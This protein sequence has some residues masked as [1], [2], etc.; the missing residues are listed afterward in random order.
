[1]VKDLTLLDKLV[2]KLG[3]EEKHEYLAQQIPLYRKISLALIP[4]L[5]GSLLLLWDDEKGKEGKEF[6]DKP[7]EGKNQKDSKDNSKSKSPKESKKVK[8]EDDEDVA[9]PIGE[10]SASNSFLNMLT[11]ASMYTGAR[12]WINFRQLELEAKK[13]NWFP[14]EQ[15]F[16][17]LFHSS[18]SLQKVP[19]AES[20]AASPQGEKIEEP[21]PYH[22]LFPEPV[23]P[24][25]L[26]TPWQRL[27]LKNLDLSVKEAMII[28]LV[29]L[30]QIEDAD[31]Q[32]RITLRIGTQVQRVLQ[33]DDED[34]LVAKFD[35]WLVR[36]VLLQGQ[37]FVTKLAFC[38]YLA[39]PRRER[40]GEED[41]ALELYLGVLGFK[42]A[43]YGESFFTS[44][45][46]H[47]FW[48]VLRLQTLLVYL[49]PTEQYFPVKV[50]DLRDAE[51]CELETTPNIVSP[52]SLG[53]QLPKRLHHS[54]LD[55]SM[56]AVSSETLSID[57]EPED[58]QS[59]VWFRINMKSKTYRFHTNSLFSAR[60]WY[61]SITK[62]LFELHNTNSQREVVL[63]VPLDSLLDFQ[64]NLVIGDARADPAELEPEDSPISFSIKYGTGEEDKR[65]KKKSEFSDFLLLQLGQRLTEVF[66][67]V[68]QEH[69]EL[70]SQD[71]FRRMAKMVFRDGE[72]KSGI[73]C[74]LQPVLDATSLLI[75]AIAAV[76]AHV[77]EL[78]READPKKKKRLDL[79]RLKLKAKHAVA[80]DEE[81]TYRLLYVEDAPAENEPLPNHWFDGGTV[82]FP[83]PFALLN[84]KNLNLLMMTTQRKVAD[85]D[86]YF[87]RFDSAHRRNSD[88]TMLSALTVTLKD[89]KKPKTSVLKLF[90]RSFR[91]VSSMGGIWLAKP[92]HYVRSGEKD[93][94]YVEDEYERHTREQRF[95][96]HFSLSKDTRL[97][98]LYYAHL[99]RAIPVYG[100]LYLGSDNLCFRLLLPGLSTK[101]ILPLK[102]VENCAV[103][104]GLAIKYL[105]LVLT[106][107]GVEELVLEFGTAKGRNDC[108]RMIARQVDSAVG[109][110]FTDLASDLSAEVASLEELSKEQLSEMA[111]AQVRIARLRLLEDRICIASG[112]DFPLILEDKPF[113]VTEVKP[114]HLYRF[115]LLTIGSRGDVQP[116]IALG[117][118]LQAEGHIVTIATHAEFREWIEKHG[119]RFREIAGN[120]AELMLLMVSH[121][122]MSVSF[123]KEASAKFRG[124]IHELL[125]LS[126][127]ACQGAEIL[128]ESPSAMGGLHIAEALGIPYM[129]AFTMPWT[130]T[131][132]YPHAFIV[133]DQKRGGLYNYLTHVMFETVFWK[134]ISGQVNKWRVEQLGLSRT[135]LVRMQQ[136]KVPFLY[137]ISPAMFPPAVDFPDWIK[138]T[139]YWFLD[140]GNSD[141]EPP[142]KLVEFL[143]AARANND[144]LVYV[145]FGL[146]VVS[147]AKKLTAA[148]VEAVEESGVKCILN[149]GWLDRGSKDKSEI[150]VELPPLIYDSGAIPHDWIF[151]QIDAAVHHGGSG[152]T[153][154]TLRAGLP[155][156]IK[157]FFGDQFFYALRIEEL[158]VGLALK[159]LN[160]KSLTKALKQVTTEPRY[161]EKARN[162]AHAM[163]HEDGVLSAIAAIYTELAYLKLLMLTI[164][165]HN[166]EHAKLGAQTPNVEYLSEES[167]S[168]E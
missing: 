25:A 137:N 102:D 101:M 95:R 113:H 76:N 50:I 67:Q 72:P 29:D 131:R 97:V 5:Q 91:T 77:F 61:N 78:R 163:K 35:A 134:G 119:L 17:P 62:V 57:E 98:A 128:I 107:Q 68:Y 65:R 147:D 41:P 83:K 92:N 104:Q 153:G 43:H 3:I 132:A 122:S 37:I 127:A 66:S 120:P 118:G 136:Q 19:S 16:G 146:I 152:T 75:G 90:K 167:E 80:S 31:L 63:R 42:M 129:R 116:Y 20:E 73:L 150:E 89:P 28:K 8:N 93:P 125:T 140:E 103:E 58:L 7:E 111:K 81:P 39:M 110:L 162:I 6:E 159:N 94:Y 49:S 148:V 54:P 154:A 44:V 112:I 59:G 12:D 166:S 32:R 96:K 71:G 18:E 124:W 164:K 46:T 142:E 151:P 117:K 26:Q 47:N 4:P 135:N 114:A 27:V 15:W 21:E 130:R 13:R 168:D 87:N 52:T 9:M 155:T 22:T 141:Y 156:I 38:F 40:D 82:V 85:V 33:L 2:E 105:G 126:W 99:R 158:G 145:G 53:V 51:L 23:P 14:K 149:K 70:Y 10:E 123:L 157:P 60:H 160:A 143:K 108:Q 115:T 45:A 24:E 79:G 106:V 56:H 161:L 64:K 88:V 11:T 74:T 34:E 1:M 55:T 84:L 109:E 36:D 133:P 30:P 144:K 69:V 100:K 139:G 138:V 86:A 48:A 165:Q 121:G